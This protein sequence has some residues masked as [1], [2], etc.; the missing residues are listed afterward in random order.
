MPQVRTDLATLCAIT[1]TT[2]KRSATGI[3][4]GVVTDSETGDPLEGVVI[5]LDGEV[6]QGVTDVT[7]H[8]TMMSKSEPTLFAPAGLA[9]MM[10]QLPIS[11]SRPTAPNWQT[12]A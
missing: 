4:T 9:S 7:G 10:A 3:I 8:Y 5:L 6:E 11:S 1:I 12:S 2:D